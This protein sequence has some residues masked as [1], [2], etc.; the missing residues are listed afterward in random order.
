M[1]WLAHV[2]DHIIR[3][4]FDLTDHAGRVLFYG[5]NKK[6]LLLLMDAAEQW[7]HIMRV[8]NYAW[9]GRFA[10][11]PHRT[12]KYWQSVGMPPWCGGN[13]KQNHLQIRER[14]PSVVWLIKNWNLWL[15]NN[16]FGGIL[17]KSR[18]TGHTRASLHGIVGDGNR[19][20]RHHVTCVLKN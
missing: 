9:D 16:E 2:T 11:S 3:I 1:G 17:A 12:I 13:E 10:T 20:C 7:Q 8:I 14:D 18:S 5:V 4:W 6:F 19:S 15:P